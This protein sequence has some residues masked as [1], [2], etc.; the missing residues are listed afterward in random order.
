M[1]LIPYTRTVSGDRFATILRMVAIVTS[2]AIIAIRTWAIWSNSKRMFWILLAIATA[3]VV[4]SIVV[5]VEGVIS[6]RDLTLVPQSDQWESCTTVLSQIGNVYIVPYSMAITFESANL[7]ISLVRILRWRKMLTS[8][9]KVSLIETLYRD[10]IIYFSWMIVLSVVNIVIIVQTEVTQLRVGGVQLQA[11][12]HSILATRMIL[13]VVRHGS[14]DIVQPRPKAIH[15]E[16]LDDSPN[17]ATQ[18]TSCFG[19]EGSP[20]S[21]RWS[22]CISPDLPSIT[23]NALWKDP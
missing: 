11:G 2:E 17:S 15:R 16:G 3:C 4:P 13:H 18:F 20:S 7:V 14:R 5:V 19:A 6:S 8:I 12:F 1:T 21:Y 9:R 23:S 22:G 10:G